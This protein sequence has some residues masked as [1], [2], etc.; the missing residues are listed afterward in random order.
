MFWIKI[1]TRFVPFA[2]AESSPRKINAGRVSVE[3]PPAFTF[4]NPAIIPTPKSISKEKCSGKDTPLNYLVN[5]MCNYF[6]CKRRKINFVGT[7][8][9]AKM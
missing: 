6:E 8:H 5:L 4:K 1:A 7:G 3:P 2:K 9:P